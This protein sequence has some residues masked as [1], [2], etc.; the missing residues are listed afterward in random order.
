MG[1]VDVCQIKWRLCEHLQEKMTENWHCPKDETLFGLLFLFSFPADFLSI[2]TSVN[3]PAKHPPKNAYPGRGSDSI[4]DLSE[5]DVLK[6]NRLSRV[7]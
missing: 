1:G 2:V 7:G 4:V 6:H 5:I 3:L